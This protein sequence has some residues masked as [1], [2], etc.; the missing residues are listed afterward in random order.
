MSYR[1]LSGLMLSAIMI[2][3]AF[4]ASVSAQQNSAIA[5]IIQDGPQGTVVEFAFSDPS[6]DLVQTVEGEAIV[7]SVQGDHRLL[8]AGHPDLSSVSATLLIDPQSATDVEVVDVVFVEYTDIDVAPSQG[9]LYRNVDPSEV[10]RVPAAM[11]ANDAFFPANL[12]VLAQPFVQR[13]M[14]GQTLR[15]FPFQYNPVQRVLR[16]L[17]AVTVRVFNTDGPSANQLAS[18]A[19]A[20]NTA[21]MQDALQRR[22]LNAGT[23]DERYD[24]I[25][26]FGKVIVITD[27]MYDDVLAP[28]VQWKIEKGFETEVVYAADLG[29]SVDQI[30]AYLADQ[31]TNNGLTHVIIAGDEDQVPSELVVN[32]G[33]SGFCDPCYAFVEG[34]DHYPEFFV[35]RLLTH[36]VTEMASVVSRTLEYEKN[37]YLGEDWFT[38]AVGIGSDEGEGIGDDGQADW[39]QMNGIKDQLLAYSFTEV[40]ELYDGDQSSESVST[41]GTS[42]VAGSPNAND[43]SELVNKGGSFY[44]YCGHGYHGGIATT[45]FDVNAI[46]ELSNYGMYGFMSTVACCVGDF[47]EGEGSGDC[48]GEA[49]IKSD[50]PDGPIGGI[51]GAFSSVL[52]SW[53]PPME[54]QDEMVDLIVETGDV[55]IGHTTG[56]IVAHGCSG[57]IDEYGGAGEEMMDT[58]CVFGD[59]TVML[60]TDAP[61]QLLCSHPAVVFLGT[62]NLQVSCPVEGALVSVTMGSTILGT[63]F[64]SGGLADITFN[65]PLSTPGNLLVT[66]TAYNTIPYQQMVSAVP[67]DGPYV[68]SSYASSTDVSGDLDGIVDQGE[69]IT[70]ELNL[71]NVGVEVAGSVTVT[72]SSADL[73]VTM[74]TD[75]WWVGDIEPGQA[76]TLPG[77]AFNVTAGVEDQYAAIF[78]VEVTDNAGNVWNSSFVILLNAPALQVV[79]LTV[80]DGGNGILE[81]GE[82]ADL[83]IEVLNTGHDMAY[84]LA[85]LI[86]LDNASITVNNASASAGNL[87][88]GQSAILLYNV[89]ISE[90]AGDGELAYIGFSGAAGLYESADDFI[91]IINL[92]IENWESGTTNSFPWGMDGSTDW[93]VTTDAPYQGE[94]CLESGDVGDDQSTS[95]TISLEFLTDGDVSFARRVSTEDGWDYLYFIIDGQEV[96]S[97]SGELDWAEVY[98]PLT[99]GYHTLEWVYVK[100]YIISSGSDACWVDDIAFPPF[101][102]IAAE[103]TTATGNDVI[104]PGESLTLSTSTGYDALWSTNET[105]SSIEVTASGSYTVTLSDAAG[106][107]MTSDPVEVTVL[108]PAV[109]VIDFVGQLQM[110]EGQSISLFAPEGASFVWTLNGMM[111]DTSVA[112]I[113]TVAGS[114]QLQLTDL[115]NQVN[116]SEPID[117]A[118]NPVPT[119]PVVENI[120]L[121]TPGSALFEGDVQTL[122]WFDLA[123][124]GVPLATGQT[125]EVYAN[126]TTS[127]WVQN[128]ASYGET[129]AS[130]GKQSSDPVGVHQP[131]S[132]YHLV[133]DAYQAFTLESV[134]VYALEAGQQTISLMSASGSNLASAT[135]EVPAGQSVVELG[136]F[137]PSGAD[138]ALRSMN[139][140]PLLWRDGAGSVQSYP[141]ALGNA[142]AI[143]GTSVTGNNASSFYYFFYDW[144]ISMD[145]AACVSERVEVTVDVLSSVGEI[146]GL[147]RLSVY[148]NPTKDQLWIG[149]E[150]TRSVD[151][152]VELLDMTGR[153]IR[154]QQ[155]PAQL[156]GRRQFGLGSCAAGVYTLRLTD[157]ASAVLQRVIVQ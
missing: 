143:T 42:D 21:E 85:G 26:E 155:W 16:V 152:Q 108:E 129:V 123:S 109:P 61:T 140:V 62:S 43:M 45:G 139:D 127:Y 111:I 135:V 130:G 79:G 58:W 76:L 68:F 126:V 81:S 103:V 32:G 94:N 24:Y 147:D 77:F 133:F 41:D 70:L 27:P 14:R 97:W 50:G 47:D 154:A 71:E 156:S 83:A 153:T 69:S 15:V 84:N 113:A 86:D 52:Q 10:E 99:A 149:L 22:F 119:A 100:D 67:A 11:Y 137:V 125:F 39:Q 96:D 55:T 1:V 18:G 92:I 17:Q 88:P 144:Q 95:L 28:L 138:L 91:E 33:G 110:C 57:M 56:S 118:F 116:T 29:G 122:S 60:R 38:T 120:V 44:N 151:L 117:I 106:C 134:V 136:F 75:T 12:A 146:D 131:N 145:A 98:Y 105:T 6:F 102:Y 2:T 20:R 142:G 3:C 115:C 128:E 8:R 157:G 46:V 101:C 124:G 64:A 19:V 82:S 89:T 72:V 87:A 104:C 53:A 73:W 65:V 48:F 78:D 35:G 121:E 54:G 132:A 74:T 31:Y 23:S 80:L 30:K 34:N 150:L 114:Y 63:A 59:P 4:Q 36:N 25:E 112:M 107:S 49:W 148:P 7:P 37:P 93:F 51:G 66:G 40:W 13:G 141:Y 90:D 5:T 9:N